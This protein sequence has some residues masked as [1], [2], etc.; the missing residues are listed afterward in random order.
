MGFYCPPVLCL[1]IIFQWECPE[2]PSRG[3]HLGPIRSLLALF[4][5]ALNSPTRSFLQLPVNESERS[6]TG[7]GNGVGHYMGA[8]EDGRSR[9][10]LP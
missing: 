2:D 10:P 5:D 1:V 9:R 7:A 4:Q 3:R 8:E 6:G